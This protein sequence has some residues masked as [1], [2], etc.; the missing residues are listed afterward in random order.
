VDQPI[1]QHS[2]KTILR[3]GSTDVPSLPQPLRSAAQAALGVRATLVF[4]VLLAL[5]FTGTNIFRYP[6]YE[7]DEGTYIGSAWA[8]WQHGALSYYTYT[9]DHPPFGWFVLGLWSTITGGFHAFG[10]S[11]NSGRVLML[12]VAA[13]STALLYGCVHKVSRSTLA[14]T[15]AAVVFAVS[16]L[17]VSLHR[18]IWLDNMA[19]MWLLGSLLLMLGARG[20]LWHIVGSAL[21]FGLAFWTKEVF[22][23]FLPAMLLVLHGQVHVLQR[24]F[25]IVLWGGIALSVISFFVLLALLKDEFLPANVLWSSPKAHVSMLETFTAQAQRGGDGPLW[26][27]GSQFRR[28]WNEWRGADPVLLVGGLIAA[29]ASVLM[30][31]KERALMGV[32]VLVLT[33][34]LFLGRGGVVLFYYIIPVLALSAVLLGLWVGVLLRFARR[35]RWSRAAAS[36]AV[37]VLLGGYITQSVGANARNFGTDSTTSQR[38]AAQWIARNLAPDSVLVMDSYP[39]VDLRSPDF[40]G[41]PVFPNAHYYWPT[42]RDASVHTALL[43]DNWRNIDYLVLSPSTEADIVRGSLAN[44]ALLKDA[45]ANADEVQV[46]TSGEWAVKLLRVRKLQRHA[47]PDS[48]ILVRAWDD[49]RGRFISDGR[50]VDRATGATTAQAQA[51]ALIQAVY[52]DDRATF[53]TLAGWTATNLRRPDGTH[54]GSWLA[55]TPG[56]VR[57]ASRSA[58]DQDI[59]LALLMAG[60]QWDDA[61]YTE[62]ATALLGA[63]WEHHTALVGEQ[64]VLVAGDETMEGMT[65]LRVEPAAFAPYAY[66]IFAEADPAH[67]W[68]TLID[69]GYDIIARAQNDATLGGGILPHTLVVDADSGALLPAA[70]P[71]DRQFNGEASRVIWRLTLDW[72]WFQDNRAKDAIKGMNP[73]WQRWQTDDKLAAAYNPDGTAA[74]GDESTTMYGAVVA[75]LLAMGDDAGTNRVFAEKVFRAYREDGTRTFWSDATHLNDQTSGWYTTALM[76]GALSNLYAG[77][78]MMDWDDVAP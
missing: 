69:S 35:W 12:I 59:A 14:A 25:A 30:W 72:L 33:F 57:G 49:F 34:L 55:D 75:G 67:P 66:R 9:Y 4:V 71:A 17:G 48:P 15:V 32:G 73:L 31:R 5:V 64:R 40:T 11:I 27:S 45:R 2:T 53:D 58:A 50:V 20:R 39:W 18:Q 78:R 70:D 44:E 29:L 68:T 52:M 13:I 24:R 3:R 46:W 63:I 60:Q 1:Q 22:V 56:I 21:L 6:H 76:D 19:T 8:M 26:S 42:V 54:A 23:V 43:D 41:G 37:V 7:S 74:A 62:Q 77:E 28:F 51:D 16:P 38:D 47:A 10:M 65:G 36:A 61:R